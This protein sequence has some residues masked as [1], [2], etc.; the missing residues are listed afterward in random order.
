MKKLVAKIYGESKL[1]SG[2]EIGDEADNRSAISDWG[3]SIN[4]NLKNYLKT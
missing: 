4:H 3:P 1:I 2:D